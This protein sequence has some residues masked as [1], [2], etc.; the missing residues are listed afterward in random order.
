MLKKGIIKYI[1][2]LV[3][4]FSILIYGF[5]EVNINKPELVKEKSKFTMNFKLNPLDFRIETKGY[6]FYTNGKF[7][8]N[9][10]GKCIDTYNEI[11]MK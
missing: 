7:F 9:I 3:I 5:V 4:C 2:I 6:V 8:Y 1:F 11:F 10:K